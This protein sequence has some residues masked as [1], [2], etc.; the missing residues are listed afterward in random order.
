MGATKQQG[1][2]NFPDDSSIAAPLWLPSNSGEDE[3]AVSVDC[4]MNGNRQLAS[5]ICSRNQPKKIHRTWTINS[6][7]SWSKG[8]IN[9][10]ILASIRI[11]NLINSTSRMKVFVCFLA[12]LA[13]VNAGGIRGGAGGGYLPG[14]GRGGGGGGFGG[15]SAIGSGLVSHV[16]QSLG[17]TKVHI[18][19]ASAGGAGAY[20]GGGYGG[21]AA[22]YG[23]GAGSYGG[24]AGAAYGGGAG[25]SYGGGAASYGGGRG[26]GGWQGAGAG[27]GGAGFGRGGAGGWQGG[28]GGAG[29]GSAWGNPAEFDYTV[30]HA[31]GGAGGAGGAY[32]GAAGAYGGAGGAYGG[33]SRGGA[34]WWND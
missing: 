13:L 14:G 33:G 27:R 17:N 34:G 30:N 32:G 21:G 28:A 31:S 2:I 16:S 8:I 3:V 11:L 18:A 25:A 12:S 23:G 22:S 6:S 15:R 10:W 5:G 24:G 26:A 1:E 9:H 19:G 7:V 29:A 20:G 4:Q